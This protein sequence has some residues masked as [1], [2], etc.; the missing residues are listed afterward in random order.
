MPSQQTLS[1]L[2]AQAAALREG[3]RYA[4]AADYYQRLLSAAPG[5][6]T[7]WYNL[8]FCLRRCGRFEQALQAYQTA[9]E[10]GVA[11]PE[12]AHLNRSVILMDH[13]R[14][15]AEA[16]QELL[17]ALAC[18]SAYVPALLN[19]ANLAEDRGRRE[20]AA[21]RYEQL[22]EVAP[23]CWQAW[24]R[25]A[26]LRAASGD[27]TCTASLRAGLARGDINAD[28]RASLGFALGDVLDRAGDYDEAFA[29]FSTANAIASNA[30]G[31]PYDRGAEEA[32]V[33][34]II[35]AFPAPAH[36]SAG[37]P[38]RDLAWSPIFICGMFRSG[39]TLAE[40]VLAGHPRL[41]AGGEL[42]LIPRLAN[43][44]LAPF[45]EPVAGMQTSAFSEFASAYESAVRRTFPQ[46]D[47]LT[48]KRPENFLFLGL[49]KRMFPGA[50]IVHSK[51]NPLDNVLSIYFLQL[52]E[53]MRYASD[54]SNITH[55]YR[56]YRRLMAHWERLFP[57]DILDFDYD[58]FVDDPAHEARRL[59]DFLGLEWN[60]ACLSFHER[61]NLVK[62]ASVW[63][64]REPLYR[65]SS[66]RWRNYQSHLEAAARD[67]AEFL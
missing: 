30:A 39:S 9:I 4:E 14:R 8:G 7:G 51:R 26:R 49:I 67:L 48:D 31:V 59:T 35:D 60:D 17:K 10:S 38:S 66:G 3:G 57:S 34:S 52:D 62:T 22:L 42:G 20:Q 46:L 63:Q 21:A 45:P 2:A 11:E 32:L 25:Y 50:K 23:D 5:F 27:T 37:A 18:N 16:E 43:S 40:Q 36:D 54:L 41:T 47:L 29:A 12:E 44:I 28:D 58:A 64:V 33:Q 13:L 65:R 1:D 55:H 19:L 6:A 53:T 61:A 56:L 15:E 24:A